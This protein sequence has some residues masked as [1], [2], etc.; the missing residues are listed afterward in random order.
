[1]DKNEKGE[2]ALYDQGKLIGYSPVGYINGVKVISKVKPVLEVM[3]EAAKKDGVNLTLAAGLRTWG[4]QMA[5]RKSNVID[6][7]KVTDVKYL[8]E[9]PATAFKPLTGKPGYSNHHDG[10]A[11]D[12]NVTGRPEV[13]KWLSAN[14]LSF[15]FVRTIPSERWHWELLPSVKDKFHFVK[16]TDP[17]WA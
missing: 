5:L 12:F 17:S 6:K 7:S 9:A 11:Y 14:A 16:S 2:Y 13:F 4:E 1:M 15:G 8:T 3:I 10:I